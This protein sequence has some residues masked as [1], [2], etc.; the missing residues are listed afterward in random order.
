M[1]AAAL[2]SDSHPPS[3]LPPAA[4]H[5]LQVRETLRAHLDIMGELITRDKNHPSVIMWS[6][7]NE[8][9]SEASAAATYFKHLVA[10][11][12]ALDP[13]RPVSFASF[14][15]A[16]KDLAAAHVDVIMINKY[17]GWYV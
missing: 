13:S 4:A 12:K 6:V 1:R 15:S 7:A 10:Q 11:T 9:D 5:T 14:K 17:H 16:E 2:P 3:L 8:P